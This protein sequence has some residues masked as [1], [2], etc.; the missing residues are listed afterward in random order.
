MVKHYH[1]Y[2][3][4]CQRLSNPCPRISKPSSIKHSYED[5]WEI[6]RNTL[7]FHKKLG[8]G[9]FSEVWSG[10]W[11]GEITVAIKA[12]KPGMLKLNVIC[13]SI[14]PSIHLVNVSVHF[15]VLVLLLL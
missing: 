15:V 11:N 13:L 2:D 12:L 10:I 1:T 14:E 4:L 7:E 6:D 3:G 9:N 8:Q 5:E